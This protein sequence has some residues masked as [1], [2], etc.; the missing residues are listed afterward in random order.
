MVNAGITKVGIITHNNYQSLVDHI[1][2]G[3]DWDLARHEGGI[4]ILS[5]FI[6]SHENAVAG[7][8]Y[9][10]RLE[11]LIGASGFISSSSE[12]F[13]VLSDCDGISNV[14]L[15]DV[16]YHHINTC[17]DLTLV[18]R[19]ASGEKSKGLYAITSGDNGRITEACLCLGD[20]GNTQVSTNIMVVSRNFL[21]TAINEA[22]AH[23]FSDFYLDVIRRFAQ[24]SKLTVYRYDG[25]F[26]LITSLESY[27]SSSMLLLEEGIREGLF[28]QKNRPVYTKLKNTAPTIYK[29]GS[30]VKNS[31]IADG[32]V[33]EWS[34]ENSIIFPVSESRRGRT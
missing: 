4:K 31:F 17:S 9:N 32:C 21:C 5:P 33:I 1:G 2:T 15:S 8:L 7:K 12:D 14:D 28:G 23:G 30:S 19:N 24:K 22:V 20:C 29:R 26:I 27:F 25:I 16:I 6:S 3:K 11:A 13:F 18:T 34:V 10:T